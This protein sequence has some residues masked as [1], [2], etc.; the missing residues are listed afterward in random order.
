MTNDH[1]AAGVIGPAQD[2]TEARRRLAAWLDFV[3]ALSDATPCL[4]Y[5][6]DDDATVTVG[7]LRALL[8]ETAAEPVGKVT[9][10]G[11]SMLFGHKPLKP[12]TLLY[13]APDSGHERSGT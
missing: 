6:I 5:S 13:A 1:P 11:F 7:D 12:G 8:A 4:L 9:E 10:D 2:I 3:K